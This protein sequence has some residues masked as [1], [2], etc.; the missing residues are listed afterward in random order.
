MAQRKRVSRRTRHRLMG[1]EGVDVAK[2][3]RVS[4]AGGVGESK[5]FAAPEGTFTDE[6]IDLGDGR[7]IFWRDLHVAGIPI[8]DLPDES[9][10]KI[11]FQQTDEGIAWWEQ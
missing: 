3:N 11:L 1:A 2:K 6:P 7:V 5:I 4:V 10:R 8:T 9:Q